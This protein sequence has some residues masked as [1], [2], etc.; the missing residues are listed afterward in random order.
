MHECR[1]VL[2]YREPPGADPHAV[3]VWGPGARC[4][5]LPDWTFMPI[6]GPRSREPPRLPGAKQGVPQC[7]HCGCCRRRYTAGRLCRKVILFPV[8]LEGW[9]AFELHV[10]SLPRS[11]H[12]RCEGSLLQSEGARSRC[13]SQCPPGFSEL[14]SKADMIISKGQGN[15]EAL[16]EEKGPIFFLF[17]AKCH[18]VAMDLGC[19]LRDVILLY[20]DTNPD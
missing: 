18:V 13:L 12:W 9:Y 4:P 11:K 8:S 16:S 14:F 1:R 2:P 5:R 6:P 7:G 3:V 10:R 15:F 20:H 17:M 19:R